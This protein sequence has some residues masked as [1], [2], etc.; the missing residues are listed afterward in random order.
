M[1]KIVNYIKIQGLA[2][3]KIETT[4]RDK[5]YDEY[6]ELREEHKSLS[7]EYDKYLGSEL[8]KTY[9]GNQMIEKKIVD[10][11]INPILNRYQNVICKY[12]DPLL[13]LFDKL[14]S[15]VTEKSDKMS[16]FISYIT[17]EEFRIMADNHE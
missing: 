17:M 9:L 12:L 4:N 5:E 1:R 2:W 16:K 7:K 10:L 13:E 8:S 3:Q 6:K 14:S 11:S 15:Q